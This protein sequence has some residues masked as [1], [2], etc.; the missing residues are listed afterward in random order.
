MK[1]LWRRLMIDEEQGQQYSERE[2]VVYGLLLPVALV[3]IMGLA[4]WLET[5]CV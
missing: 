3:I 5:S 4:G 1:E 2:I